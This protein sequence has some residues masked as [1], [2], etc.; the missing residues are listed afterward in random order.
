M[1]NVKTR[2]VTLATGAGAY[3]AKPSGPGPFPAVIML[4]EWWGLNDHIRDV[5]RRLAAEGYVVLALDLYHGTVTTN[6]DEAGRLM[7]ALKIDAAVREM[8]AAV[9]FLATH[10]SVKA[11]RIGATGFCMGGRLALLAAANDP[12]VKAT[13]GWYGVPVPD[14]ATLKTIKAE[15]L[16]IYGDQDPFVPVSEVKR[17]EAALKAGGVTGRVATYPAPH[18]FFND[19]RPEVYHPLYAKDAWGKVLDL[20]RRTLK[21]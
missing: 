5:A 3:E 21:R 14:D 10:P 20:F 1:A 17:L 4:H 7:G 13:A 18:A 9:D 16:Y 12:R 15:V 6:P 8:K 11:D 2:D 19:T